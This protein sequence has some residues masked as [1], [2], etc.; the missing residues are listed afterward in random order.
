[1]RIYDSKSISYIQNKTYLETHAPE[2]TQN[3]K[4]LI[5]HSTKSV[6]TQ[7]NALKLK[8]DFN[9]SKQQQHCAMCMCLKRV[10]RSFKF[11]FYT[12]VCIYVHSIYESGHNTRIGWPDAPQWILPWCE[13]IQNFLISRKTWRR[14]NC[15]TFNENNRPKIKAVH[16][17]EW[18][19]LTS[20][21]E[22]IVL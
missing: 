18:R 1:M 16:A 15:I 19:P 5:S 8:T 3:V 2:H 20:I 9:K 7:W 22:C 4:I 11:I 10:L 12:F 17:L 13:L 14:W 6:V 21:F